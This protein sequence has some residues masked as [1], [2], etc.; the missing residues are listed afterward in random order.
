VN[1]RVLATME[2][3]EK[4]LS[5][6]SA[7]TY[8]VHV[9]AQL[10][11]K[12][13]RWLWLF[14]WLL[15]IPHYVVLAFLWLAFVVL[16]V[17]AFFAIL[18]TGRYPRSIFEFNVGVLRWQWRVSY[19][20]YGALG[21]DR[22]PPFTLRDV[23]DYP[24]HL[25]VDYPG[26]LSRGLVLVKWWLL[27]I[28]H[29]LVVG[30]FLGG[31]G[32]YIGNAD[33][34]SRLVTTGLIPL[35]AVVAGVVVL[36]TGRYPQPLFDLLLGL[37]RWVLRV[38]GY[39]ALMTDTYPPFQL[40]QGGHEGGDGTLSVTS[41]SPTAPPPPPPPPPVMGA[42]G[43][44]SRWTTGR[45]VSLVVGCVMAIGALGLAAPG[46]ALLAADQLA[47]DDDGF[48]MSADQTFHTSTYAIT[49]GDQQLLVDAP[50][51]LTPSAL[52]GDL[53]LTATGVNGSA[54]FLGIGPAASVETYLAGVEHATLVEIRDGEA[55][56][57]TT[58]GSSPSSAPQ[59]ADFWV[60]EASG[61]GVQ[62]ITWTP[63]NGDWAVLVMD[64]GAGRGVEV[65]VTAGAEVPSVPWVVGTLLSLAGIGLVLSVVLIAVPLRKVSRD[66]GGQ[67]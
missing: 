9:D 24:A 51:D 26:R 8:P 25:E 21:T 12:V 22:Y 15:A 63:E 41:P 61:T 45:I 38:A 2:G 1:T 65:S 60:A 67:Q 48:L 40:D 33:D 64:A 29:Y 30:L 20:A 3:T 42:R 37:N 39:A 7:V 31:A 4:E 58:A 11:S 16:S 6:M 52:L 5:L 35:L 32:Y 54:V 53:K 43:T 18:F 23:P 34:G 46:F 17:V 47:R 55:V 56:Y 36:L 13:S 50:A 19:Y 57:R 62:E 14:K 49:S 44:G 27:A 66:A 28:P 10:D 59:D